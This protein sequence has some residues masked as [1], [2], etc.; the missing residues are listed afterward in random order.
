M[1]VVYTVRGVNDVQV[2]SRTWTWL[3]VKIKNSGSWPVLR[4]YQ[5]KEAAH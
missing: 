4:H 5:S 2:L 1:Y 3:Q